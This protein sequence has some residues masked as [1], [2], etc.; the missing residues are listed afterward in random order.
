MGSPPFTQLIVRLDSLCPFLVPLDL[1][2]LTPW[3]L[4][5]CFFGVCLFCFRERMIRRRLMR[6]KNKV[7]TSVSWHR[8]RFWHSG[9]LVTST[10]SSGSGGG[11][12]GG[13]VRCQSIVSRFPPIWLC[14]VLFCRYTKPEAYHG[15]DAPVD[16]EHMCRLW[17]SSMSSAFRC[18][19]L[20]SFLKLMYSNL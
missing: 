7:R 10:S 18:K 14:R 16:Q 13:S 4:G 20:S 2:W 12:G 15:Q 19:C 11:S 9:V 5:N 1:S 3:I 17:R 8:E 6:Q